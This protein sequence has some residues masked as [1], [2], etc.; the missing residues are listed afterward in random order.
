MIFLKKANI[1][2]TAACSV[3]LFIHS[4][5]VDRVAVV[6]FR[7]ETELVSSHDVVLGA[8]CN[9]FVRGITVL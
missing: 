7:F 6:L 9:I 1:E 4:I 8:V 2:G 5:L 3:T